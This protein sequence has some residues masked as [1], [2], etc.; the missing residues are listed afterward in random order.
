LKMLRKRTELVGPGGSFDMVKSVVD[1]GADAVYVGPKGWSRRREK[2]ELCDEDIQKAIDFTH[3]KNKKLIIAFNTLASSW[4]LSLGLLKIEKFLKWGADGF[5]MTDTG[6][7]K[8][9][10]QR[11]PETEIRLS[12]GASAMNIEEFK[13][14]SDM[15][16]D[17]ITVPCE[18]TLEELRY[19]K[20][21]SHCGIEILIHA[22]RDFTYLGRCIMSS[23]FRQ[24]WVKDE[25]GKNQF[26]GSPNR[27]GLCY[28]VCKSKWRMLEPQKKIFF[29]RSQRDDLGNYAFFLFD[30][31]PSYLKMDIDCLK[32]QGR[33][34]SVSLIRQ[35]V[36]FYREVMDTYFAGGDFLKNK[37]LRK[38]L[39][40]L[41]RW[42]DKERNRTTAMLLK[43]CH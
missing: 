37:F 43:E 38:R 39:S 23:Y 20:E 34:Y 17:I 32:I 26:W 27:G 41:I 2:F 31:I 8:E 22:N 14:Y 28:R 12:V 24:C 25:A 11:F 1:A 9:V 18:F 19:L 30:E 15:G 40:K 3:H 21:N 36:S 33:E 4:E 5:I 7:I 35:I 29:Q 16:V 42:R 6:F 10:H 13:F